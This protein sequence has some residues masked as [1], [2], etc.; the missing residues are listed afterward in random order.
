MFMTAEQAAMVISLLLVFLAAMQD[1]KNREVSNWFPIFLIIV[2]LVSRIGLVCLGKDNPIDSILIPLAFSIATL[3][4]LLALTVTLERIKGKE[5]FGGG[6]IK[7]IASTTPILGIE[8]LLFALL[9]AF[10]AV[11][12]CLF[13]KK[14]RFANFDKDTTFPFVPFFAVGFAACTIV[15]FL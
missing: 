4:V 6:D 15:L 1:R 2:F 10:S 13:I 9:V 12:L 14:N 5:M 3:I 11:L 7:I 8:G